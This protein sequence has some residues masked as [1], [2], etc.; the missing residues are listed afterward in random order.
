MPKT[1]SVF[2]LLLSVMALPAAAQGPWNGRSAAVV[3]TYDDALN[4]HQTTVLP[5][6]DSLNLKAT[7]YLTDNGG[8][9]R[10]QF[11]RWK[12]AAANGHELGNHSIYHPC[13]GSL[14]GRSWVPPDYDLDRYTLRR[15]ADEIRSTNLL[16]ETLDGKKERTFA[17]PCADTRI[18]DTPYIDAVKN[19]L[20]AARHVRHELQDPGA[21][22]PWNIAAYMVNG[23]SGEKLISLVKEAQAQRKLLVFLFHGVGGEHSID[24]STEAH[25]SL[26]RYLKGQKDIWVAPMVDVAKFIRAKQSPAT[27]HTPGGNVPALK[28]VY[29]EYFPMGVAVSPRALK[30]DEAA[31]ITKH[32]SSMTPENAMKMGPIHPKEH[33][34]FWKD[35]DSIAAFAA[36]TGMKLRGHTLV[37]HHQT[38]DWMF[39][40]SK[41]DTVGRTVL[42][43]RLK[44]HIFAVA[45]RYKGKVYA[46]DVANEVISDRRDEY[47]RRSP[48]LRIIGPDFIDSA[49]T[50]A[51]QAD[52]AAQ[53][54]YNDYNEISPVKR[55]KIFRLVK[56]LK[57]RGIPIHGLGLQAHWAVNEPG[58]GQ[59][60]STL[61]RFAQLGV[62]LQITELDISVYPKEHDARARPAEDSNTAFSAAREQQQREVYGMT[63][64]LFRKYRHVI[65][66]VT[67]WNISDRH[68]WLDDF[69]VQGRKDYPLLFDAQLQPKKA[70]SDVIRFAQA[71]S[72][73]KAL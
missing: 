13:S 21:V 23:E 15:M 62:N 58:R 7:F 4:V 5:L 16:L 43:Q 34:Y 54:F 60:D 32:F 57:D 63:F 3:L 55:E 8:R 38:P 51:H 73:K 66:G 30:T 6:L 35:A 22:D 19:E 49:F 44:E 47:L 46:W 20:V 28:K 12:K 59:L 36:R 45:G 39:T 65:T 31:L 29:A 27:A 68:S 64:E 25:R 37:W 40:D 69:P 50:W 70:F 61:Q 48:W 24:V 26:V 17:Y 72:G 1:L 71:T 56:G 52:P 18:H 2:V 9:L 41:G 33:E 67:F 42:L 10:A 53:L 14:P 11:P